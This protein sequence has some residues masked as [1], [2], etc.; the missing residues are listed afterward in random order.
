MSDPYQVLG[1][2]RGASE[3][4]V[5][6]AY[7]RL[8]SQLHPDKNP[9][10]PEAEERLKEVNRAYERIQAG[11]MGGVRFNPD[12]TKSPDFG[13]IHGD[14]LFS[15]FTNLGGFGRRSARTSLRFDV[16]MTFQEALGGI[17]KK[18]EFTRR[19]ACPACAD[20]GP[21]RRGQCASC[22]GEGFVDIQDEA[23]L[24]FPK[25][26]ETG[27]SFRVRSAKG[28]D[29]I[30][31]ANVEGDPRWDREGQDLAMVIPVALPKLSQ[32]E[33]IHVITPYAKLEFSIPPGAVFGAPMRFQRQGVR[34]D[35]GE[36][37]DLV[38]RFLVEVPNA[39]G[40]C[41]RSEAYLQEVANW[42]PLAS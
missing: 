24:H 2:A 14:D 4:D 34:N 27:Q 25:G 5:K 12:F 17:A 8:A 19:S 18:I 15:I 7:R 20:R 29:V 10:N 36:T 21:A 26:V 35:M 37:G 41:P 11:D 40:R 3:A 13:D 16:P 9:G 6:Q 28:C 32:L 30:G 39:Q 23:A 1:V 22:R 31:V 38:V 33:P 42:K